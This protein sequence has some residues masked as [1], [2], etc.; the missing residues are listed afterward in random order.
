MTAT[1]GRAGQGA[2]FDWTWDIRSVNGRG[3]DIRLRLP[4]WITGLDAD[5]RKAVS[6]VAARG[7]ITISM[8]INRQN[9]E[10]SQA[11]NTAELDR[12][13]G[14][15]DAIQRAAET[16]SLALAA[17]SA[18]DI[19]ALR[20]VLDMSD[21]DADPEV[22]KK[23]V[24]EEFAATL[25][26]F[27]EMRSAE[28]AALAK[29][30]ADQLDQIANLTAAARTEAEDAKPEQEAQ[31]RQSVA[32]IM[33]GTDGVEEARVA[34][35]LAMLAMKADITEEVDRLDAHV[36]AARDLLASGAPCGRK[37]DFLCQEFNREAN[38]LCSKAPSIALTRVGL[39]LKAT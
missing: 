6:A 27:A 17:T 25:Q 24:L 9:A 23:A 36:S 11:L 20:G 14:H 30:L 28:G 18:A 3:L 39:D 34:Q 19:L 10:S 31:F 7:N 4:E 32:R 13:L 15:L 37:L 29:V 26:A 33:D 21:A 16:R 38:T 22:L 1:A 35:E 5:V 12:A 8:R 2:G